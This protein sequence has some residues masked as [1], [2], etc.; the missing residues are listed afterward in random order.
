MRT[1]NLLLRQLIIVLV[2]FVG[3]LGFL[4]IG[5]VLNAFSAFP[6]MRLFE[7]TILPT[8]NW[9]NFTIQKISESANSAFFNDEGELFFL[10]TDLSFYKVQSGGLLE[11]AQSPISPTQIEYISAD[12]AVVVFSSSE[13]FSS[14]AK[15]SL[16][17]REVIDIEFPGTPISIDDNLMALISLDNKIEVYDIAKK[18]IFLNT[19]NRLAS[20]FEISTTRDR[21]WLAT[22]SESG[23][24]IWH[25][26]KKT[27]DFFYSI[28]NAKLLFWLTNSSRLVYLNE[29]NE[30]CELSLPNTSNNCSKEKIVSPVGK[31]QGNNI[32]YTVYDQ[33]KG[34]FSLWQYNIDGQSKFLIINNLPDLR[35]IQ[36]IAISQDASSIAII[37]QYD[38]LLLISKSQ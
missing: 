2:F 24:D 18:E 35:G 20:A 25:N 12:N 13:Y 27:V 11:I 6:G 23:V 4:G 37:T 1:K 28:P 16:G 34:F 15:V 38:E 7:K 32:I 17:S 14:A 21:L 36:E 10:S 22:Q 33:L 3:V 8:D 29:K 31:G 19:N 9:K 30:L 5:V 26:N